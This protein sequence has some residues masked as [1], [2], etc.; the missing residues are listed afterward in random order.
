MQCPVD[1]HC[2]GVGRFNF[3]RPSDVTLDVIQAELAKDNAK[4]V[5]TFFLR[6][7]DLG[8]FE[9]FCRRYATLREAGR[10]DRILGL[11]L[12]GPLL[13]V[14]GGTPYFANWRPDTSEWN[15]IAALGRCGLVY[16]VFS[17]TADEAPS[18]GA[19]D[20]WIISL[21]TRNGVL[22]ALGHFPKTNPNRTAE[23]IER[24]L[25]IA[26]KSYDGPIVTD[27][28]FNDMPLAFKH[29]WRSPAELANRD[30]D[31]AGLDLAKWSMSNLDEKLGVV[32]ATLIRAAKRGAVKLSLNF[33]G[34]HVD[35]AICRR[36]VDLVGSE[37]LMMMTDRIPNARLGSDNLIVSENSPLLF[38][39]GG[40]VAG[41]RSAVSDQI[42]NMR[43]IGLS[44]S[45]I[46]D[47]TT[48]V[49]GAVLSA[50]EA[51]LDSTAAASATITR[52]QA[53]DIHVASDAPD[54]LSANLTKR[55]RFAEESYFQEALYDFE[56]LGGNLLDL[57]QYSFLIFKPDAAAGRCVE[58][59]LNGLRQHG[60]HP[61]DARLF[62]FNRTTIRELW[63]YEL[64][65]STMERYSA[66]DALLSVQPSLLVLLRSESSLAPHLCGWIRER[67]GSSEI[68]RRQ[69]HHIRA[70]I[71]A[72][73]GTLNFIHSPDEPADLIR[74]LGVLFT[75]EVRSKLF[76]KIVN[77]PPAALELDSYVREFYGFSA[78]HDFSASTVIQSAVSQDIAATAEELRMLG[79]VSLNFPAFRDKLWE[80][81]FRHGFWDAMTLFVANRQFSNPSLVP[82]LEGGSSQP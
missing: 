11:A 16:T 79:R 17:V 8:E 37:N 58:N 49:A 31:I 52:V 48:H 47:I 34:A 33:D 2:H 35:L 65:I 56:S 5:L 39:P 51:W 20:E 9:S 61:V 63:R 41:S 25:A 13:A 45:Q 24:M 7:N 6:R 77:P 46:S 3:T 53:S 44:E 28:L 29:A 75:R 82:L 71:G 72:G 54:S 32:P 50:R 57:K 38:R 73:D 18:A 15:R 30:R 69:A 64:N 43:K 36:T 1:F 22:P 19:S 14:S 40:I 23:A 60:I 81:G 78:P 74:E 4:A 10:L 27:H 66:I 80:L 55:R 26:A 12:E 59:C 21:L 70:M 68:R 42:A 67:K 76:G 62:T